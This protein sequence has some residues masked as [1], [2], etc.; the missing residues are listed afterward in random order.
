MKN[1]L[2]TD[3]IPRDAVDANASRVLKQGVHFE[4]RKIIL[5]NH[6]EVQPKLKRVPHIFQDM[7]GR[8]FGRFT[9]VG[10]LQSPKKM[11][12]VRCACG[13]YET[14]KERSMTNPNNQQDCCQKC[15]EL[16][17]LQRQQEFKAYGKNT[18]HTAWPK[19]PE[20]A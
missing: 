4:S 20:Q 12:V 3:P 14:R 10:L 11:W 15:R 8:K 9:V 5:Q 1:H 13:M 19:R 6:W 17:H 16:Q 7:T 2:H 18:I